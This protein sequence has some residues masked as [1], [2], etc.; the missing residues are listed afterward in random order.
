MPY[1]EERFAS[2]LKKE[3][4]DF[5]QA[6][7]PREDGAFIS[8]TKVFTRERSDKAEVLISIFPEGRAAEIFRHIKR[9]ERAA[10]KYISSRSRRQFIPRI[11]FAL[12][13]AGKE[14]ELEKLLEKVKN[15]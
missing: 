12:S 1:H 11:K 8:V 10:R 4:S 9:L 2:F 7:V 14:I 3:I 13:G 5:L 6:N 15:E